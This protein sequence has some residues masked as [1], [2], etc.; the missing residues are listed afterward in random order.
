MP[1]IP[2][3]QN[4]TQVAD[5]VLRLP[6]DIVEFPADAF[7]QGV[8]Y[9][10]RSKSLEEFNNA[11]Q[12]WWTEI[13]RKLTQGN[14]TNA[15]A[16]NRGVSSVSGNLKL[17][18]DGLTVR[19]NQVNSARIDAEE[20]LARRIVTVSAIASKSS[21]ITVATVPPG[22]PLIN[23]YWVDTSDFANP[24]TYFWSGTDWVEQTTPL[25]VA[26][27]SAESTAR[28]TADGFLSGMYT[29]TVVAGNVVTGMQITSS[30]GT[31]ATISSVIFRATDFLIYN[32]VTG[33][34][35][36]TVTGTS[37]K[38]GDTLTVNTASSKV[39]IGVGN[40][41]N[42]D[43]PFYVD[44]SGNFS[45]GGALTWDGV[46]LSITSPPTVTVD[47]NTQVTSRPTELTDGRIAL[48]L[49]SAGVVISGAHPGINVTT[50]AA[51]LYMGADFLGYYNG[52]T[53]RTY[54]DNAGNFYLGGTSG[55]LQWNGTT[56]SISGNV[57]ITGGNA[58]KIDFS[59]VTAGYAG[60]PTT[61]GAANTIVGQGAL[62]TQSSAFWSGQVA[63]RPVELTD[64]RIA[65]ALNSAGLVISGVTP[66]INVTT[67]SAGL[68][69]GADFLGYYNG[70]AW[71]TYM[72][73]T[74]NFFLGGTSGALQ[75]NGSTLTI[76]GNI[77]VTG[78]N[79]AKTDFS[80]VTAHY[81]GSPG[82]AG[83]AN[84]IVSQGALA[85]LNSAN[86]T[87]QV[88]A[89]PVELTDGRIAVAISSAGGVLLAV[90][91]APA[92]SG[93]FIGQDFLGY[94]TGG[95]WRTYMDSSGNFYLGGTGGKLQWNGSTLTIDGTGTFSGA[96]SA[97]SGTF[98]GSLTAATGTFSGNLSAAGGT[99][100]GTVD[101]GSGTSRVYIDNSKFTY[102]YG[103][104]ERLEIFYDSTSGVASE[105]IN[106]YAGGN[107]VMKI[108]AQNAGSQQGFITIYSAGIAGAP[109]MTIGAA[110]GI[111][112]EQAAGFS[113][114]QGR[115]TGDS[116]PKILIR[117]EG[118]IEWSTGSGSLDTNLYRNG[119]SQLKTDGDL[120]I[121]GALTVDFSIGGPA[122]ILF[123]STVGSNLSI[124]CGRTPTAG[125]FVGYLNLVA[126]DGTVLNV[127]FYS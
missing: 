50:G 122:A 115:V 86:W 42:N 71:R 97:A 38:L 103:Q 65:V 113:I 40:Y 110:F 35:M 19:I 3:K 61:G 54:M 81:A 59:N 77:S 111:R 102:G 51:G 85:T 93:L 118:T 20:A 13:N 126:S 92:G 46:T 44:A 18:I 24:I 84:T 56:L 90:N 15:T 79:A 29:L 80:N 22:S 67:G 98:A 116:T 48:A 30:T 23:D 1:T 91:A 10:R 14:Q 74:G 41:A 58:A 76:T 72:D 12:K 68:Y 47:W 78:G 112:V 108:S 6:R 39:Y 107:L 104:N 63:G 127:P 9:S 99:F 49:S 26:A 96:L 66:G 21:N 120:E 4:P 119:A 125:S 87:T 100:A 117:P 2:L 45:L 60:S 106:L 11:Q 31:G 83:A 27:V 52:A 8:D 95:S 69:L 16:I 33:V 5:D 101:I 43:T 124:G 62:A 75:W 37:I 55:A 17:T 89:R 94:Y 25:S 82:V 114:L 70:S 57:T 121:G 36:F 64:G 7:A 123:G 73:N 88:S 109:N 105:A 53:W 32:S 34:A 28:I